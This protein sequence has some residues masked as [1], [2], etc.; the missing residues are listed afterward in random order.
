MNRSV[1]VVVAVNGFMLTLGLAAPLVDG[2]FGDALT[3]AAWSLVGGVLG[4]SYGYTQGYTQGQIAGTL[5]GYDAGY[6]IGRY[7]AD[8]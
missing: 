2:H 8:E 6:R 7:E 4:L 1:K 5:T 3:V